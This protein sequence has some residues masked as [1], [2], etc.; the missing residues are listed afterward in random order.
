M[1][2]RR[3]RRN[4]E[5]ISEKLLLLTPLGTKLCLGTLL[6]SFEKLWTCLVIPQ[7][8]GIVTEIYPS[9]KQYF[10]IIPPNGDKKLT[11]KFFWL[12]LV[13]WGIYR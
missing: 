2:E 13:S 3:E 7:T 12:I 6:A 11:F 9:V 1:K 10:S 4:S 5:R 8:S